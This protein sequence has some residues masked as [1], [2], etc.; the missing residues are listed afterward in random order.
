MINRGDKRSA[1][2]TTTLSVGILRQRIMHTQQHHPTQIDELVEEEEEELIH[3]TAFRWQTRQRRWERIVPFQTTYYHGVINGVDS[4]HVQNTDYK[5]SS[6]YRTSIGEGIL[7][8]DNTFIS[9]LNWVSPFVTNVN[10]TC[11]AVQQRKWKRKIK[12]YTIRRQKYSNFKLILD[13]SYTCSI[14]RRYCI[15]IIT[16]WYYDSWRTVYKVVLLQSGKDFYLLEAPT[17]P[18]FLCAWTP[19]ID[20]DHYCG[21]CSCVSSS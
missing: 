2:R 4:D 9:F 16:Y 6:S 18:R 20:H 12:L 10:Q 8:S 11:S 19:W 5:A 17:P 14:W 15:T 13:W 7:V 3:A 1:K 21:S